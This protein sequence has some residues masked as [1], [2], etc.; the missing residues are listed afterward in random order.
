MFWCH[1][2]RK[3]RDATSSEATARHRFLSLS[4]WAGVDGAPCQSDPQPGSHRERKR[5]KEKQKEKQLNKNNTHVNKEKKMET[6]EKVVAYRSRARS[7][8][9]YRGAAEEAPA[10]TGGIVST[11]SSNRTV[12]TVVVT[13]SSRKAEGA[14][15]LGP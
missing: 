1:V 7:T 14:P 9:G 13:S 8:C 10:P 12:L 11:R 15:G 6:C 2:R 3:W 4:T 5:K